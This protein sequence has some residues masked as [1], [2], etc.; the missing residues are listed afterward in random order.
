ML[1]SLDAPGTSEVEGGLWAARIS[2]PIRRSQLYNTLC[3]TVVPEWLRAQPQAADPEETKLNLPLSIL[4]A[5][6]NEVNREVAIG[7]ANKLGCAV[8]VARNGREAVAALDYGRHALILMDVQMPEMDGITATAAIRGREQGTGRHIPIIAMTAHAMQGDRERCLAAGMD[9]YI[10]K[11]IRI[12]PLREAILAWGVKDEPPPEPEFRSFSV[13]LLGVSCMNDPK[14]TCEV[15]R[16][17]LKGVPVRL[18]RLETAVG[19]G[20]RARVSAEAHGLKGAFVTVGARDLAV[21][22][23]DLM[24]PCDP[25]D[26]AAIEKAYQP[27]RSQWESLEI[28]ANRYLDSLSRSLTVEQG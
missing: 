13:K 15:L 9:D 28:E 24:S 20:D 18:E 12:G 11:P 1:S 5:E 4:L 23:Q 3:R 27:I 21:A 22:C 19:A 6:D 17:M 14:L 26:F 2:N 10:S 16:L 7:M 25:E 8:E